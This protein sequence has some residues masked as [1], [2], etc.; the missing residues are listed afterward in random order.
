MQKKRIVFRVIGNKQVGMGHVY[1]S[2]SLAHELHEHEIFFVTD[3]ENEV[4][5]KVIRREDYWLGVYAPERVVEEIV[6]LQPN[7]VINDVLDTRKK[8]IEKI[9]ACGSLAASFEDLGTG[10][11]YT[12]LTINELYDMPRFEGRN[13]LWGRKYFFL[14][15]E[16]AL[17]NSHRF[18]QQ[19]SNVMLAFGG[20]DQHDLARKIF[21][22]I[23]SLC[24][25]FDINIH[26]V[27][28]PGYRGYD[29]LMRQIEHDEQV[30]LT[31]DSQVISGLMEQAQVAV[32]SNGRTVYEFAHMNI[33][34]IV[35][36]QHEREMTHAFASAENG[37]MPLGLYS[38]G[39]T[40][41]NARQALR[42]L[43]TDSVFR[44]DLY[45]R[46]VRYR[47]HDNKGRVLRLITGL[48][49]SKARTGSLIGV[50]P[51]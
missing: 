37:F 44:K 19:V 8:D 33:P 11:R 12:D 29:R 40:E 16:F 1:R 31:H 51:R 28:G 22:A 10:A 2:L 15:E 32:T 41:N 25:E 21:L 20:T 9:Q 26:I 35:I 47:F 49:A 23:R 27:T 43:L 4:A 42:R 34:A 50:A 45:Q 18:T 3:T 36:A 38:P 24:E 30:F 7:L 13:V 17:A 48:L 14:R 5:I 6:R 46:L 39:R